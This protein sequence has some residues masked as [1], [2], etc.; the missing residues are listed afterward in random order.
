MATI[1]EYSKHTLSPL[2][3]YGFRLSMSLLSTTLIMV[4][5]DP[6]VIA[7]R[8][9][10]FT[11]LQFCCKFIWH[12]S[13]EC[14]LHVYVLVYQ[15]LHIGPC[16]YNVH[17]LCCTTRI[18]A[19]LFQEPGASVSR[20]AIDKEGSPSSNKKRLVP[21]AL[22]VHTEVQPPRTSTKCKVHTMRA[23]SNSRWLSIFPRD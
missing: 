4:W 19:D 7:Y 12:S 6:N 3:S 22:Q 2:F 16:L 18:E 5:V 17:N 9:Y 14:S 10:W 8:K 20:S 1:V 13:Y 23:H 15:G 11:Y 21:H